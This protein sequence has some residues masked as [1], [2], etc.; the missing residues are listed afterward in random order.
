[1]LSNLTYLLAYRL[2][3][4]LSQIHFGSC[5]L[6]SRV[7]LWIRAETRDNQAAVKPEVETAG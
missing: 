2:L 7:G 4:P 3:G 1:M 5:A 6:Y